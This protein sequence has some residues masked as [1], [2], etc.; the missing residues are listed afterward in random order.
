M[1]TKRVNGAEQDIE[2]VARRESG[3]ENEAEAVHARKNGAEEEVW[4]AI[5][6]LEEQNND[7]SVGMLT[8]SD[9]GLEMELYKFMDGSSGSLSGGGT[10]VFELDGEWTD[11]TIEFEWEGEMFR[12]NA[13]GDTWYTASAGSVSL[14]TV[15]ADGTTNTVSAVTSIGNTAS[16]TDGVDNVGYTPSGIYSTQLNGTYTKLGLS[17]K[18]SGWNNTFYRASSEIII[19]NV[20]FNGKKIGFPESSEFDKLVW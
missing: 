17:I 4:S 12:Y 9:D 11:P 15:K 16:G 20:K 10:I 7:I 6:W 3:A 2:I 1:F 5:K 14:Y 18:F 8:I 13:S 19:K